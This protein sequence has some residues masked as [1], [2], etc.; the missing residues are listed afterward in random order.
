MDIIHFQRCI[1]VHDI[2][3]VTPV[4]RVLVVSANIWMFNSDLIRLGQVFSFT[5]WS[6]YDMQT[7]LLPSQHISQ[8][9]VTQTTKFYRVASDI[10]SMFIA[11]LFLLHKRKWVSVYMHWVETTRYQ[12]CSQV[13]QNCES[14]VWSVLYVILQARRI[15]SWLWG[16]WKICGPLLLLS[17]E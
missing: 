12:L 4:F 10:F 3:G 8:V 1:Y 6:L 14:S 16:F 17:T 11:V 15:W 2:L 9:P 5:F 7:D 13:T